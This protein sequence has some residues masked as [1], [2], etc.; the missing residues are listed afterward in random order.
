[1]AIIKCP[2]C[3]NEISDQAHFC[4]HCALNMDEYR[5]EQERIEREKL[6]REQQRKQEEARQQEEEKVIKQAVEDARKKIICPECGKTLMAY[7]YECIYCGFPVGDKEKFEY[8]TERNETIAKLSK[9]TPWWGYVLL[10]V[11][12]LIF[13][14][15]TFY[16]LMPPLG[17]IVTFIFGILA[18]ITWWVFISTVGVDETR[19]E[20]L[21]LAQKDY[22]S[23]KAQ[24]DQETRE[25][26]AKRQELAKAVE[27]NKARREEWEHPI[28]PNCGGRNTRRITTTRRIVDAELLGIASS[29]I[30]KQYICGT[31]R[32]KW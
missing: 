14:G 22:D 4:I 20:N 30:G 25:N 5:A 1:M 18:F 31:C 12:G 15:V 3:G 21:A 8:A 16:S 23:Y 9:R 2:D 13:T 11:L 7:D 29:T 6:Q 28:C 27:E 24:K 26:T 19:A 17:G 10:V 32:H